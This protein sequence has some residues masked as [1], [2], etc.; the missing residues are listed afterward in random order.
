MAYVTI[1]GMAAVAL[2]HDNRMAATAGA[3]ARSAGC[4]RRLKVAP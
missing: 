2:R 3:C 1:F 4:A